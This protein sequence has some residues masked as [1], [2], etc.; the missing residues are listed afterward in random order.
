[1][2]SL[3]GLAILYV[4][5]LADIEQVNIVENI[6]ILLSHMMIEAQNCNDQNDSLLIHLNIA[7]LAAEARIL[8]NLFFF[9][10]TEQTSFAEAPC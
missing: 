2:S 7:K 6:A 4:L 8:N 1:M 10:I 9:R 3:Q 5:K